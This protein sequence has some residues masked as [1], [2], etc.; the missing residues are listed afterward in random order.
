MFNANLYPASP[1]LAGILQR[2]D[3]PQLE[4]LAVY[5]ET[6]ARLL[7]DA[8][9][10]LHRK[11]RDAES[12]QERRNAATRDFARSG[13]RVAVMLKRGA[14]WPEISQRVKL[15]RDVARAALGRWNKEKARR[16]KARR[17]A[18]VF[19]RAC[20]GELHKKIARDH[21][22][23]TRQVRAII[24]DVS[25]RLEAPPVRAFP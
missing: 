6:Q 8:A 12:A 25:K 7:R 2:A 22:I 4:A 21:A 1:A 13:A 18:D 23:T 17:D 5:F 9:H 16:K 10:E 20:A 14:S 19:R 15:S 24:A 11:R 3:A